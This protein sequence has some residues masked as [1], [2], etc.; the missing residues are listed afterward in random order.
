[1]PMINKV[2][3]GTYKTLQTTIQTMPIWSS[4]I[5]TLKKSKLTTLTLEKY[6][7]QP[8]MPKRSN[9]NNVN[10]R[11]KRAKLT[12]PTPTTTTTTIFELDGVCGWF[13]DFLVDDPLYE[14]WSSVHSLAMVFPGFRRYLNN[15]HQFRTI[16]PLL[17]LIARKQHKRLAVQFNWSLFTSKTRWADQLPYV[18]AGNF[19]E[20]AFNT[21]VEDVPYRRPQS[22]AEA[23]IMSGCFETLELVFTEFPQSF[24]LVSREHALR[25]VTRHSTIT[26]RNWLLTTAL[27]E[28]HKTVT[29][30]EFMFAIRA[31]TAEYLSMLLEYRECYLDGFIRDVFDFIRQEVMLLFIEKT[32][33][34]TSV[35]MHRALAAILGNKWI[36][37]FDKLRERFPEMLTECATRPRVLMYNCV[38]VRG[39]NLVSHTYDEDDYLFLPRDYWLEVFRPNTPPAVTRHIR[40]FLSK[41]SRAK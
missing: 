14:Y 35:I 4:A 19:L 8:I 24:E 10:T 3:P 32:Q 1:M 26:V 22:L 25:A 41:C 15:R 16:G 5:C 27:C 38:D 29:T 9:N 31:G 6:Y 33:T 2:C 11:S 18:C 21:R 39:G 23:A 12:T 37:C 34:M 7:T 36:D 13:V 17:F 20:A 40:L 28:K 30:G